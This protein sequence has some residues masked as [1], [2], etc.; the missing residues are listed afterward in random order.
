MPMGL[1]N[2][3]CVFARIMYSIIGDLDFVIIYIDDICI[4]SSTIEEHIE[5]VKIVMEKLKAANIKINPKKCQWMATRI[6]LLGHIVSSDGIEPDEA[7]I[8]AIK[9][10][11][12]PTNVKQMQQFLGLCNYYRKFIKGFADM[13]VPLYNMIKPDTSWVWSD[14]CD[15]AFKELIKRL[16]TYPVLKQPDMI[17]HL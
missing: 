7:K 11:K 9:E 13:T 6:R 15:E 10:R 2:A 12:P 16:T 3:T 8:A 5:N 1:K 17:N 4:V 14:E